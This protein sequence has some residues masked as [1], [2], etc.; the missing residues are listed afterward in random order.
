MRLRHNNISSFVQAITMNAVLYLAFLILPDISAKKLVQYLMSKSSCTV[1][2]VLGQT[3]EEELV[4][5]G[6]PVETFVPLEDTGCGMDITITEYE[7]KF[8]LAVLAPTVGGEDWVIRPEQLCEDFTRDVHELALRM[9][10]RARVVRARGQKL[11]NSRKNSVFT[12][13][14]E[15]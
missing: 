14:E 2:C 12:V 5:D 8:Q 10:E 6:R 15:E 3:Y 9:T 1:S 13:E 11:L 7:Q 4:L